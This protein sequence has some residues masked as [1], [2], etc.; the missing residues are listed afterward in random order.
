MLPHLVF[1]A[2]FGCCAA[3]GQSARSGCCAAV[4]QSARSGCCAAVGQ[5]ARFGCSAAVGQSA[6][7]GTK[8]R[9]VGEGGRE[10]EEK[11]PRLQPCHEASGTQG[12]RAL[13]KD[14]FEGSQSTHWSGSLHS[15]YTNGREVRQV[16]GVNP[17]LRMELGG[18]S[19][20]GLRKRRT[21][22]PLGDRTRYAGV[23]A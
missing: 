1:G 15:H 11:G 8:R 10:R 9:M 20:L 17:L 6:R 3:V 23:R 12:H 18:K 13:S 5:S 22:V 16:R 21:R 2:R 4:G 7:F 19:C 14:R